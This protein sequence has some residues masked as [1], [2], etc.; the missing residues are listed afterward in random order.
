MSRV[1]HI[2][3]SHGSVKRLRFGNLFVGVQLRN[4]FALTI[5]LACQQ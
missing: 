1:L 5:A 4:L 3:R 2:F